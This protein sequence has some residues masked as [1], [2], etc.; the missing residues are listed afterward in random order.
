LKQRRTCQMAEKE[1]SEKRK[2]LADVFAWVNK[3]YGK[4]T[5][6]RASTAKGLVIKRI[7]TGIFALDYALGGGLPYGRISG[8]YGE[9]SCGK[10]L[11][12][13]R[14]I[15]SAQKYCR[16]H[17]VKCV[18]TDKKVFRCPECGQRG[19]K[20][21]EPCPDC[22][23][24]GVT[25]AFEDFGDRELKCPACGKHDPPQTVYLDAEGAWD[26]KWAA[27]LGVNCH[28]VYVIRTEYAEQAI[29]VSDAMLRTDECDILVIDTL[30]QLTPK[31]EIVE[32]TEKN[33][34]GLQA[35]LINKMLRKLVSAVNA[36]GVESEWRPT[37]IIINQTRVKLG[38]VFGDPTT[39]PGGKGQEFATTTDIRMI[40]G[41]YEK[42][43]QGNTMSV[44][45][46]FRV[47]KNKSA[48][49]Q[50][51][52]DFRLW[53][54]SG[55]GN[56]PGSTEEFG[57]VVGFAFREKILGEAG[58]WEYAGKKFKTK[59]E[60]VASLMEDRKAF[61]ELRD[62]LLRMKLGKIESDSEAISVEV[63]GGE[64]ADED[65][66]VEDA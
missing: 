63:T 46:R 35:R 50:Q 26:N 23:V 60:L 16:R 22:R 51:E 65:A 13:L 4:G 2:S 44:L 54:R 12:A 41:K 7:E 1:K 24:R 25:A 40:S 17:L 27:T 61:I 53:L 8:F 36:A 37:V 3:E 31:T 20:V 52:G 59:E 39:K 64:E 11:V 5:V 14:T 29:D 48:P 58:K 33:Q 57:V 6:S 15:A 19:A 18:E 28:D 38:L 10:T 47:D 43:E 45:L 34:M 9:K 21:G 30:A 49:A 66:E 56:R 55:D 62:S 42:D 32:S